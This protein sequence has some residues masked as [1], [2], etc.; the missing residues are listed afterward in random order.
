M[1]LSIAMN[2]KDCK[3]NTEIKH[4][5][6]AEWRQWHTEQ[7][8]RIHPEK[9]EYIIGFLRGYFADAPQTVQQIR[10]AAASDGLWWADY[11]MTWGMAV[12]NLLRRNGFDER[13]LGVEN[14]DDVWVGLVEGAFLK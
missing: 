10:D 6:V 13:S 9:V 12:R 11:H 4:W 8:T 7:L 5:S 2:D 3:E 14:L 1:D